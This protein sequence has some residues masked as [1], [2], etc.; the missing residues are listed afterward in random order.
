MQSARSRLF[1]ASVCAVLV[2]CT[3]DTG[4]GGSDAGPPDQT[5]LPVDA[6]ERDQGSTPVDATTPDQSSTPVDATTP[7]DESTVLVDATV[8]PDESTVSLDTGA[9]DENLPPVDTGAPDENLPPVDTVGPALD[10]SATLPRYDWVGIVGNGQSLSVGVEGIPPISTSAQGFP[11]LQLSYQGPA[12]CTPFDGRGTFSLVPLVEPIRPRLNCGTLSEYPDNIVGETPHSGMARQLTLLQRAATASDYVTVHTVAGWT[13]RAINFIDKT[14]GRRGYPGTISEAQTIKTLANAAGKTFGYGAI[15][16]THGEADWNNPNYGAAVRQLYL[17]YNTDLKA[18]TGQTEDIPMLLT[19]QST[20]PLDGDPAGERALSAQ[21]QW[22]LG[23]D[24]PGQIIVV[25][26]K[27]QYSY[28]PDGVHLDAGSYQRLGQKY[29]QVYYQVAVDKRPWQPLQPISVVRNGAV[30]SVRFNVPNPPLLWEETIPPPH[31]G[32]KHTAWRNGRGFEVQDS[33]G[34][35]PIQW[36]RIVGDTVEIRL[37]YTP[38]GSGLVVRH[39]MTQD[40]GFPG[41][42]GQ[43]RDSDPFAG[44][45]AETLSCQ[46]T[47]GSSVVVTPGHSSAR[48]S[49]DL[50]T[51]AGLPAPLRIVAV[52]S[53]TELTLSQPWSGPSGTM[54]LTLRHDHYNYAVQFE[55]PVP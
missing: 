31:Q 35:I 8:V 1:L 54:S 14:G 42:R 25:G 36:V 55:M 16:F 51:G 27:Y 32:G 49:R 50:V 9:P 12:P 23:I 48:V 38:V 24:N 30:I 52:N 11:N 22:R 5:V 10:E 44:Y 2:A 45:D 20:Y 28:A 46:V 37:A 4:P 43:L 34:E 47:N 29:A 40:G 41:R 21:A 18:V 3:G 33:L 13:G 19:Q 6:A 39:A 17:D 26:P 53:S 15:I 7:P